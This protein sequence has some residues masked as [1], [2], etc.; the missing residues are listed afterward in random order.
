MIQKPIAFFLLLSFIVLFPHLAHAEIKEIRTDQENI[1]NVIINN[2]KSP[3]SYSG[4]AAFYNGVTAYIVD[5]YHIEKLDSEHWY[6]LTTGQ[7]L[8]VVGQHNILIA[9]DVNTVVSFADNELSWKNNDDKRKIQAQIL[10]KSDLTQFPQYFQKLK[11][12]HLWE[13]IRLLCIGIEKTLLWLHSIHKFG[14]GITIILLSLLFKIFILPANI[15][16]IRSQRKVSYIQ[17]YLSPKL[18]E[19]N[20]KFSGEEAHEKFM[21]VHKENGV[22]PF[23][24]LKPLLLTLVPVPFLIAIFNVLGEADLLAGHSF[25]WIKDFAHPDAIFNYGVPI[26]LLG[27]TINLLPFLMTFLTIFAALIHKNKIISAR[28]LRKQK[29]SLYCMAFGFFLLFY[30]FPSVMVLYWTF[31]NIWQI[32]QQR[33]IRV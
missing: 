7:S 28:E 23:Y 15:L 30:P 26:I 5:D 18:L 11:Y 13:P 3:F 29:L 33:F 25:L 32:I 17:A 16:L 6:T 20:A 4:L 21:A 9:R 8:A 14:W 19:I 24:T 22:T 31:A 1:N 12:A 27:S 10:L 2:V